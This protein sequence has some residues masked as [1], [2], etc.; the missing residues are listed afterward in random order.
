M[1]LGGAYGM[2]YPPNIIHQGPYTK[3]QPNRIP[4]GGEN[5]PPWAI[6]PPMVSWAIEGPTIHKYNVK[7]YQ[8]TLGIT[9]SLA[10]L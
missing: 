6:R 8:I 2:F 1:W 5:R 9:F 7:H 10:D 4:L 3:Y